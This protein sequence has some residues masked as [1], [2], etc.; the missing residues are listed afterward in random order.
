M[1]DVGGYTIRTLAPVLRGWPC[2][3]LAV[4]TLLCAG[5]HAESL[6]FYGY[7]SAAPDRDRVKIRIDNPADNNPG[8]PADIGDTDFTI[9]FWVRPA[10]GGN[11]QGS[12][13]CGANYNWISGN[14]VIDRDRYDQGRAFGVSLGNG[15][16]VFGVKNASGV[17]HTLCG[18]TDIRADGGWHHIVLQRQL[19]SG[20]LE[21][22]VD[23]IREAFATGPTGSLSYPDDGQPG[24]GCNGPCTNSDPFI[25]IGA[26]KHD[27]PGYSAYSGWL[28][29]LR[30]STVRRYTSASFPEPTAR[31]DA[32]TP[33]TAALYHFNQGSG[34]L[35]IDA[36]AG[37]LSP[38]EL[39]VGGGPPA[40]PEWS[41]ET[42]FT[43]SPGRFQFS[44]GTY[45]VG[46]GTASLAITVTRVGGSAGAATVD[47]GVTGG[48]AT[49]GADYQF[50]PATL[51]WGDG[52]SGPRTLNLT[53]MNDAIVEG[54]ETIALTL[55]NPNGASLGTPVSA[56]VTI[57]D[58]DGAPPNPGSLQFSAAT[59]IAGEAGAALSIS[60][61]RTGG[62]AGAASVNVAAT[63]TA[64][65]GTDYQLTPVTLSWANGES[66]ARTLDLTMVND[67]LV[68]GEETVILTLSSAA[69]A[70]LGTPGAATVT[71]TDDDSPPLPASG[72]LQFSPATYSIGEA[73][74]TVSISVTRTGGSSGNASVNIAATGGSAVSGTDYQL[75]PTTLTWAD[76][77]SDARTFSIAITND[78]AVESDETIVLTLSSA[79]GASLG[80][81]ATA[82]VTITNDDSSPAPPPAP[83]SGGGGGGGGGALG[84]WW[85]IAGLWAAFCR[86]LKRMSGTPQCSAHP[87]LLSAA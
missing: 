15:R 26:E 47:V 37:S 1:I 12:I 82:T 84:G 6:R 64:T 54:D 59:Y 48:T 80:T 72:A 71:I 33:N 8:P 50:A 57:T 67:A 14:I 21:L 52:E 79:A 13:D 78:T 24:P 73:G 45:S 23:G 20:L 68:E 63:G 46:E 34:N 77:Q 36:T 29:E 83:P 81:P 65:I 85:L 7:G 19:N 75:P 69:G 62:A 49:S 17:S 60:V 76:G 5:A 16:V 10:A 51:S 27:V 11:N 58:D 66:G 25:V 41:T 18:T 43:A 39:R 74:A 4:L 44:A 32:A 28:T 55:S 2:A 35:V 38:G 70:S 9:E 22:F 3:L 56:T 87:S 40:G 86:R 30:L 42:P 31:F 53:V 61:M